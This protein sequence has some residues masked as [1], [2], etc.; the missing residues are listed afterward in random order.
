MC[1]SVSI[2]TLSVSFVCFSSSLPSLL[3]VGVSRWFNKLYH[4][5]HHLFWEAHQRT[6]YF[7]D[8]VKDFLN[9]ILCPDV[10][11]RMKIEE[12]MKHPWFLGPTISHSALYAELQRRKA[13][14]DDNK[15]R[16]KNEKAAAA[17][18]AS[19]EA[20]AVPA[21]AGL[22]E[23]GDVSMTRG[24][25]PA[26]VI[27]YGSENLPAAV[28]SITAFAKGGVMGAQ[29]GDQSAGES[30]AAAASKP[31]V[32]DSS[33]FGGGEEGGESYE[34]EGSEWSA[35]AP[36]ASSAAAPGQSAAASSSASSSVLAKA[37]AP[38]FTAHGVQSFTRFSTSK[39]DSASDLYAHLQSTLLSLGCA[40]EAAAPAK[41]KF[42]LVKCVTSQG[43]ILFSVAVFT[44]PSNA[45]AHIV[46]FKKRSQDSTQFRTLYA[47][48][49]YKLRDIIDEHASAA[50]A[51]P[52]QPVPQQQA[53]QQM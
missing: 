17:A 42:K 15:M 34:D 6:A 37:K 38:L 31:A 45:R 53:A 24:E 48:I 35:P 33:S 13:T 32:M 41:F 28:P 18:K 23:R 12:L 27:D 46:E 50:L 22:L 10:N 11:K 4:N 20:N 40:I 7:S 30:A 5:K 47:E 29:V 14:V 26:V 2:L 44:D 19:G 16:E 3:P 8:L 52:A 49:R 39:F 36:G 1:V 9:K 51:T 43:V 25:G 21:Q